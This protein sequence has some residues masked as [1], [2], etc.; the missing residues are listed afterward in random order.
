VRSQPAGALVL[1]EGGTEL[2][3]TP[4]VRTTP[5]ILGTQTVIL[6]LAGYRDAQLSLSLSSDEEREAEL[7][8]LA[9]PGKSGKGPGK[10]PSKRVGKQRAGQGNK[11]AD[12]TTILL[13][14][15]TK[16]VLK[17]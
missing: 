16:K 1:D 5:R 12:D 10:N 17:H 13:D 15:K 9:P 3:R 7:V 11:T 8:A 6:R 4:L 2:G 14:F